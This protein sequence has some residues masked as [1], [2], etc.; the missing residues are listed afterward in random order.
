[1]LTNYIGK[2][3]SEKLHLLGKALKIALQL[4]EE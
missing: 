4:H 2:L 3:S 1:M